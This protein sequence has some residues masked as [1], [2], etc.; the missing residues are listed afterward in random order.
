MLREKSVFYEEL[1]Q[2]G[3]QE[4]QKSISEVLGLAIRL[5]YP[6]GRPLTEGGNRCHFCALLQS[7]PKAQARCEAS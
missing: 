1:T 6:D 2:T 7:N 3:L 4:L 5:R